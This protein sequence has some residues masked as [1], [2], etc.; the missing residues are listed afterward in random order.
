MYSQKN[1]PKE[2]CKPAGIFISH[3]VQINGRW[4][5]I[6]GIRARFSDVDVMPLALHSGGTNFAQ[7]MGVTGANVS[8]AG[9]NGAKLYGT[10]GTFFYPTAAT[11]PDYRQ[12]DVYRIQMSANSF[13]ADRRTRDIGTVNLSHEDR[14]N[15]CGT[16]VAFNNPVGG[17]IAVEQRL[18]NIN[19]LRV[20]GN[21]VPLNS[22]RY[23]IGG[24]S[25]FFS[26][27]SMTQDA[28]FREM[29]N[30]GASQERNFRPRTAFVYLGMGATETLLLTVYGN[31]LSQSGSVTNNTDPHSGVTLWE[32]RQLII[33][34]FLDPVGRVGLG[35]GLDGGGSTQLH[36]RLENGADHSFSAQ[37]TG[38]RSVPT[39]ITVP[40]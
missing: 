13:H 18:V 25:M 34:H 3:G 17:A 32:L 26:N 12:F 10:N 24:T 31:N 8:T 19:E 6:R 38:F 2:R 36:V 35:V 16:F 21:A 11:A 30:E 40:M 23:A 39:M 27:R 28:F 15:P 29:A 20:N 33:Q 14:S 9:R 5:N 7:G 4:V 22:I 37:T 1:I